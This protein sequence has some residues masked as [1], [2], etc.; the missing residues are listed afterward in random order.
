[1]PGTAVFLT[2]TQ[3]DV[4]PVMVWHV[5]H[6]RALHENLLVLTVSTESIPWVKRH[7]AAHVSERS[8]PASGA[9]LR[10]TALWSG[11]TYRRC[12]NMRT[13]SDAPSISADIT[14]YVGHETVDAPTTIGKALPRVGGGIVR[15]HAAQLCP[16]D[17][18]LQAAGR[19]RLSKSA[20]KSRS[21]PG[22]KE[23]KHAADRQ[24]GSG[25][26][27]ATGDRSRH[28]IGICRRRGRR[29]DQLAR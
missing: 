19:M 2:R 22:S 20:G 25:H 29:R 7:R 6:N 24:G 9:R 5:K 18:V 15:V 1:M 16:P 23:L 21:E 4:P 10:A 11:R 13:G 26:G 12:C 17:R 14:Y 8:R 28:G 27:G 3:R